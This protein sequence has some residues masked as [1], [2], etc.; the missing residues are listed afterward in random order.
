MTDKEKFSKFSKEISHI[1]NPDVKKLTKEVL[2]NADDWFF[3]EPASSS[4]KYH[5]EFALGPGGLVMHTKAVVYF[6]YELF[7]SEMY[8]IDEYHQ[9][10]LYLSAIAHDI[11]KYGE[12]TNTGHTVKNH[13]E[14]ASNFIEKVNKENK[15]ILK[16]KDVDFI[17]DCVN[18]HMGIWGDIK[19]EDECEKILHIADLLASRREIDIKF[20]KEEIKEAKPNLNEYI[21]D[22]GQYNGKPIT[23][24][25]IDYLNWCVKNIKNNKTFVKFAKQILK[26]HEESK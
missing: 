10:L 21:V 7:R 23:D 17:K 6:L 20:T 13:P 12:S 1:K 19:P 25:P 15:N 11:K 16:K 14:L 9:D 4:G 8:N 18:K 5:P 26:E 22:F 3:I 2:K 24:V